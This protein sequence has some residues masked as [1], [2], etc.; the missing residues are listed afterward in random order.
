MKIRVKSATV[1]KGDTPVF[2]VGIMCGS[3]LYRLSDWKLY[4]LARIFKT[5]RGTRAV[6]IGPILIWD[7]K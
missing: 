4:P 7:G 2:S 1:L 3:K 6:G 5:E